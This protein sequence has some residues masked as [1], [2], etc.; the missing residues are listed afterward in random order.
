MNCVYLD[1]KKNVQKSAHNWLLWTLVTGGGVHGRLLKYLYG[2]YLLG[3]QMRSVI[4][5]RFFSWTDMTV[6][7]PRISIGPS[8]VSNLYE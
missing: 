5:T 1:L 2:N 4:E 3:R 7:C 8:Y 6:D